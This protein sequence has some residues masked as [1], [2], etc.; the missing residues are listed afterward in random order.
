MLK[1]NQRM[2]ADL[3][4]FSD[5][6]FSFFRLATKIRK[7][8]HVEGEVRGEDNLDFFIEGIKVSFIFFPFKNIK[9]LQKYSQ[10]RMADD[11]DI[12][13]NKIYVQE[14]ESIQKT[15]LT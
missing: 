1:Y 14:E 3:D 4:F 15:H 8:F 2:S 13:L 12:F 5:R 9:P 11:Y 7:N 10:I 6:A